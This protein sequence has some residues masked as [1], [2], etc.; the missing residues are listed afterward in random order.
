MFTY[1]GI[2]IDSKNIF[3]L[4]EKSNFFRP[5]TVFSANSKYVRINLTVVVVAVGGVLAYLKMRDGKDSL[6]ED[7]D[8]FT[9]E[10]ENQDSSDGKESYT[11]RTYTTLSKEPKEEEQKAEEPSDSDDGKKEVSSD[12]DSEVSGET[13]GQ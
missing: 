8:D 4:I 2:T 10:F 12:S 7:F 1:F 5:A 13:S 6:D 3:V 9:D 11:E